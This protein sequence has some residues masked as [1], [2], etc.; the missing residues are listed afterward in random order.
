M[1]DLGEAINLWS[2]CETRFDSWSRSMCSSKFIKN[3]G[4][5]MHNCG[6]CKE[7]I[8]YTKDSV[9]CGECGYQNHRYLT[10]MADINNIDGKIQKR[11]DDLF[12]DDPR[13]LYFLFDNYSGV[14]DIYKT[15]MRID[16]I[17]TKFT[18]WAAEEDVIINFK[19]DSFSMAKRVDTTGVKSFEVKTG[20]YSSCKITLKELLRTYPVNGMNMH[21]SAVD[22]AKNTR[23]FIL[24]QATG[25]FYKV[26]TKEVYDE[27]MQVK[28]DIQKVLEF[29]QPHPEQR[30]P[31]G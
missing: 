12:A 2:T 5:T 13:Y 18:H 9:F 6:K 15:I 20:N 10:D 25:D 31:K 1:V 4:N 28:A 27:Y 3:K 29:V 16:L 19:L 22:I 23:H 17:G 30:I 7:P 24:G 21:H 8:V 11:L 26:T 14:G